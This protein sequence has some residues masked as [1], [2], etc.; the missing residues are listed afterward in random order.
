MSGIGMVNA[1]A[2]RTQRLVL[3]AKGLHRDMRIVQVA[4]LHLGAVLG[5]GYLRKVVDRIN[6][7]RPDL[8]LITG[9]LV[10]GPFK[11]RE[12]M[13]EPLKDIEASAYFSTGNHEFIGNVDVFL[14]IFK[15]MGLKVLRNEAVDLDNNVQLMAVDDTWEDKGV[16]AETLERYRPDRARYTILMSHQPVGFR[17][18][19]EKGVDLMLSGHTHGGQFFPFTHMTKLVWR[20]GRGLHR[21]KGSYLYTTSG[22]GT[23]GPPMRMVANSEIVLIMLKKGRARTAR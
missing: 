4:D 15:R 21:H 2:L 19:A 3:K 20:Q 23:W 10:D 7:L 18:A 12:E 14:D 16:L 5:T 6:G 17:M 11:Y 8:V 9:D 13:F 1:Y 22:A